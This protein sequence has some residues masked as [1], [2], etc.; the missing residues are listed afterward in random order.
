MNEY[1]LLKFLHVLGFAYWLG[2][3]LGT[4]IASRSAVKAGV[5]GT[6]QATAIRIMLACDLSPRLAMPLMFTV[7]FHLAILVGALHAPAWAP[8]LV[9]CIG[10]GWLA[11]ATYLA[12]NHFDSPFN[13]ILARAD[14][15]FRALCSVTLLLWGAKEC[16]SPAL[17]TGNWLAFKLVLFGWT[18]LAGIAVRMALRDF[19][20][21]LLRLYQSSDDQV[22][23]DTLRRCIL[24]CRPWVWSIWAAL[25]LNA[26]L[27][28]HLL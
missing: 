11:S 2:G 1:L 22:A 3:D 6:S 7:G 14:L 15:G 19:A 21:A 26:A 9:W 10:L 13:R 17:V 16:L 25:F 8:L 24:A 28:L 18:V 27:G 4:Y 20:P 12:L 23:I 5:D